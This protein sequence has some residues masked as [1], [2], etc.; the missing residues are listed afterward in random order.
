MIEIFEITEVDDFT[1]DAVNHLLP[2]LSQSA[3]PISSGSLQD[4][5]RS[6]ATRLFMAK[7]GN[8]ILGMLSLVVFA[9]PTGIKAWIEDVVVDQ[10]ARGKGLGRALMNHALEEAKKCGVKSIDLTSRPSR[11]SANQLYQ[12]LG[13]D[14]R[15]TNVYRY[16]IS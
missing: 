13:Y 11:E 1:L 9:I 16:K 2:Q 6:E 7:E 15:Q 5:A 10:S 12:S 8:A 14:I 4:L 3:Q